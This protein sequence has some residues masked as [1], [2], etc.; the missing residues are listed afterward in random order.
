MIYFTTAL[1]TL[2]NR[3]EFIGIQVRLWWYHSRTKKAIE[4]HRRKYVTR[5]GQRR[6]TPRPS[7]CRPRRG[8]YFAR[9]KNDPYRHQ[10]RR[11]TN[12]KIIII[13]LQSGFVFHTEQKC[14]EITVRYNII[15]IK[16]YI[17]M[18]SSSGRHIHRAHICYY[19][20]LSYP[21]IGN[22]LIPRTYNDVGARRK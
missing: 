12:R 5:R 20:I 19:I 13:I 1:R 8:V 15:T 7:A 10:S 11:V 21:S 2:R 6:S 17:I 14:I 22:Q 18:T 16:Y 9:R 3:F 4:V